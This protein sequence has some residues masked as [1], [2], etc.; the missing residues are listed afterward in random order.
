MTD[1]FK[2]VKAGAVKWFSLTLCLAAGFSLLACNDDDGDEGG[3][4]VQQPPKV[5]DIGIQ[6]PVTQYINQSEEME[7]YTYSDGRMTG[8]YSTSG[9]SFLISYNPLVLMEQHEEY[10]STLRNIKIND[11]GFMTYAETSSSEPLPDENWYENGSIT[12]TYDAEG[13]LLSENG[14]ITDSS[15]G[16]YAWSCTFYWSDGNLISS[17]YRLK[18]EEG[19]EFRQLYAWSYGGNQWP[20]SGVYPERFI[21]ATGTELPVL[22][23]SG[24]LGK[25][26]RLVPTAVTVREMEGDTETYRWEYSTIDVNYNGDR[27]IRSVEVALEGNPDYS[28]IYL[29]GY[30]GYPIEWTSGNTSVLAKKPVKAAVRGLG[31]ARR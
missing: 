15:D 22:F 2:V 27:S 10:S 4:G 12:W 28:D 30:A 14:N 3:N 8:G 6:Y 26:T 16:P 25:T 11:S 29:F 1:K 31:K 18:E 7:T 9:A 19:H 23:Y 24:L 17:E 13:H 5:T 20:N 21:Q